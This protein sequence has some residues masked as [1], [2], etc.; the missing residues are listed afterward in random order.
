MII[1]L[2]SE[3][4]KPS[5]KS[6]PTEQQLLALLDKVS[7]RTWQDEL[8]FDFNEKLKL[9]GIEQIP[10]IEQILAL[11]DKGYTQEELGLEFNEEVMRQQVE[12]KIIQEESKPEDA[13]WKSLA[14][15]IKGPKLTER[16][17]KLFEGVIKEP[18]AMQEILEQFKSILEN[19][20]SEGKRLIVFPTDLSG[21]D[22]SHKDDEIDVICSLVE[23]E[24]KYNRTEKECEHTDWKPA[25]E[26]GVQD[27]RKLNGEWL[28]L[29]KQIHPRS[30]KDPSNHYSIVDFKRGEDGNMLKDKLG[31]LI[32][33]KGQP[34][35]VM[36]AR[37]VDGKYPS[38]SMRKFRKPAAPVFSKRAEEIINQAMGKQNFLHGSN[39][40]R[41]DN[42]E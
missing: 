31:S 23:R 11:L 32:V 41:I 39:F 38:R 33:E 42:R 1:D 5:K 36:S 15:M 13:G 4:V 26:S 22:S 27:P 9:Q 12:Q 34:T 16:G 21:G 19:N 6:I 25:R 40:W 20:F 35:V 2:L 3:N 29:P 37:K 17:I 14:K 7:P 30:C 10:P 28:P 8:D 18:Q 24:Y